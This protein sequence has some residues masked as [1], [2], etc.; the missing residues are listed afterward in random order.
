MKFKKEVKRKIRQHL[1]NF[2][3]PVDKYMG[4]ENA[5]T[6]AQVTQHIINVCHFKFNEDQIQ[7]FRSKLSGMIHTLLMDEREGKN[8]YYLAGLDCQIIGIHGY[9]FFPKNEK[10]VEDI[11]K[12]KD[13]KLRSLKKGASS[14]YVLGINFIH[15]LE[16]KPKE[17]IGVES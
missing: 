2:F 12:S 1:Y 7:L 3:R 14:R 17:Q 10:E 8:L 13:M 5:R 9:Y 11:K 6:V 4:I 15:Q 16:H